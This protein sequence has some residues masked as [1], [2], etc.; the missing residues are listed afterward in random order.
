M[1]RM[2]VVLAVAAVP[3]AVVTGT[4]IGAPAALSAGSTL[5][6]PSGL[7]AGAADAA[8]FNSARTGL[9]GARHL[10][11]G[12]PAALSPPRQAWAAGPKG[13]TLAAGGATM[14]SRT[15]AWPVARAPPAGGLTEGCDARTQGG[16]QRPP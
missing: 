12:D 4:A 7:R 2:I 14:A 10:A 6:Q 5:A 8:A 11:A 16:R 3:A 15:A 9:S 13:E 1:R